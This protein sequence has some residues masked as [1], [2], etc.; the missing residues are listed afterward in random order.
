MPVSTRSIMFSSGRQ[1]CRGV[2]LTPLAAEAT[3]PCVVAAHGLGGTLD[4]GLLPFA[5]RFA[6]AGFRVLAFD[7]RHFGLSDGEPRQLVSIRRQLDD[8]AAAIDH[9]RSLPEVDADR[10]ALFGTS[11]SGGHVVRAA[12]SDAR[13]AAVVAQCPMM[14]GPAA[15][16]NVVRYAGYRM[17]ARIAWHGVRDLARAA[18]GR[19]PHRVPIVGPPGSLAAMSSAD[20]EPGYRA[21]TPPEWRNEICARIGLALPAYRPGRC[22]NRLHCPILIQICQ[23]DTVAP[24]AAAEA[25]ARRAGTHATLIHYDVG[26]FDVYLGLPFEQ[27]VTDQIAFLTQ[28]LI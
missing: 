28:A 4:A 11:F 22:A 25:A 2:L 21:I 16:A 6:Q 24:V 23:H 5:E 14:D 18:A 27:S 3:G 9:A 8:Y 10:I 26:H 1:N 20:S 15:L 19:A 7:Y 12:V 13:V 17:L